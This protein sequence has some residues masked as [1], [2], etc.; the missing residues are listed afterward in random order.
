MRPFG[1]QDLQDLNVLI[2]EGAVYDNTTYV[3]S[4]RSEGATTG[5]SVVVNGALGDES[6]KI[7]QVLASEW[8]HASRPD[9]SPD[10]IKLVYKGHS[11]V[12]R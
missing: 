12:R 10:Q 3:S 7:L 2:S 9:V 1:G 8:A 6:I 11:L 4:P 5:R